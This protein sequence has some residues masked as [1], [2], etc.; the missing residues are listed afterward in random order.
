MDYEFKTTFWTDFSIADRFGI[1]AVKDTFKR[2][3][4]EWR[5]NYIYITELALVTNWKCW[6]WYEKGNEKL[7]AL[8]SDYY[9]KV[10]DYA[11]SHLKGEE[12]TYY[13]DTTD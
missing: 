4:D 12:L 10:R 3:F 2:A 7:S 11:L 13:F 9:Y 6:E 1:S 5:D 8:Y